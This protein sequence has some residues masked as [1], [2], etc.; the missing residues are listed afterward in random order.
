MRTTLMSGG[1]SV[2]YRFMWQRFDS[3]IACPALLPE[4]VKTFDIDRLDS[5]NEL[6]DWS[7]VFHPPRLVP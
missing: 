6:L 5:Y 4:A 1:R 2:Q 3:G 7:L